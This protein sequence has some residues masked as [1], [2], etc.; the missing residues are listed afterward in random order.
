MSVNQWPNKRHT[1]SEPIASYLQV[2]GRIEP[3]YSLSVSSTH[4]GLLPNYTPIWRS[5]DYTDD[6]VY[7]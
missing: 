5:I 2:E 1:Y 7:V 4:T 6:T 3:I